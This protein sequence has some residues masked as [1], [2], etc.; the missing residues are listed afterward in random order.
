MVITVRPWF[1][2]AAL[3]ARGP[4]T[5]GRVLKSGRGPPLPPQ[6]RP[7]SQP[8]L[9]GRL[10]LFSECPGS[11]LQGPVAANPLER[12]RCYVAGGFGQDCCGGAFCAQHC[13]Y[14]HFGFWPVCWFFAFGVFGPLA[15]VARA[16][17][18]GQGLWPKVLVRVRR[19]A[20]RGHFR[21][22][23]R[24]EAAQGPSGVRGQGF[25]RLVAKRFG[26][27]GRPHVFRG[28]REAIQCMTILAV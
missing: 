8:R 24:R 17:V 2:N 14:D 4:P 27:C 26:Q 15:A 1:S 6:P 13:E 16:A 21:A 7:Q 22:H 28:G 25:S 18:G 12:R 19:L 23:F 10:P 3:A 11:G 5:G 20:R 9:G